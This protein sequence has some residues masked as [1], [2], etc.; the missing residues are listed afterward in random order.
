MIRCSQHLRKSIVRRG[1][2]GFTMRWALLLINF[3]VVCSATA[4]GFDQEQLLANLRFRI[5]DLEGAVLTVGELESSLYS[6][7]K[8]GSL[9]INGRQTL[10]FLLSEEHGHLILLTT[11]PIDVSLTEEEISEKLAEQ[12]VQEKLAAAE[13][14]SALS[15]FAESKPSRGPS[16]API[17][18]YEFS[19]FQCPYCAR[20]STVIEELLN[21]YPDEIRFVYLH[22]PLGMHDWANPAAVA[23]DCAARQSETAF[24]VL[25][26]NFFELQ[27]DISSESM[28]HRARSW[29]QETDIDLDEWQI[30]TSDE[31]STAHQDVLLQVDI[32]SAMAERF[33][34]TGTPAFFVNGYLLSGSQ[35]I[36]AF[37]DLIVRIMADE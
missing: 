37:D 29:L 33:G 23:T 14:Y 31:S 25:H 12:A 13:T 3:L 24:W 16:D 35:P 22:Y 11:N 34:L 15:R 19:D 1:S 6:G 2:Y 17:T 30:C 18:I 5:P 28:L 32:S 20:A 10:Q 27:S 21:K 7:F 26:D 4:Q 8:Q 36:E 9:T